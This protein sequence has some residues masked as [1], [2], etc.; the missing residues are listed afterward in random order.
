MS[1]SISSSLGAD[2][3]AALA[4]ALVQIPVRVKRLDPDMEMPSYAHLLDAG[5][6]L[7]TTTDAFIAPGDRLLV[8]TGLAIAIPPGYVG[9]IHP[10]SGLAARTGLTIVNTPGTIDAGYR[11]EIK[12]CL[13]NTD[14]DQLIALKRGDRIAQLVIQPVEQAEFIE[15]TELDDTDRGDQGY[16]ST[17]GFTAEY[18]P[19]GR[20]LK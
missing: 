13:L 1:H 6:D 8:E 4:S 20:R 17:G 2:Q 9:L 18:P 16:G 5:A 12:V 19:A 11:G 3:A 15:V 14:R 7:Q 10:R